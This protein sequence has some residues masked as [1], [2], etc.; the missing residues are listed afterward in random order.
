[1]VWF[2]RN[3][4]TSMMIVQ[5]KIANPHIVDLTGTDSMTTTYQDNGDWSDS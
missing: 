5:G 1:M 2:D 3:V 4:Q